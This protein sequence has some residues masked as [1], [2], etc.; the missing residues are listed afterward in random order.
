M[1]GCAVYT[2]DEIRERVTQGLEQYNK[3]APAEKR[4]VHVELFGS[5]ASG[6]Q[7]EESDIDLLIKFANHPVG[8]FAITGVMIAVEESTG[9]DVDIVVLPIPEDSLLEIERTIPIYEAA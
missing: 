4:V 6:G 5:Y 7:T 3:T 2:I 8:L 1:K 9:M